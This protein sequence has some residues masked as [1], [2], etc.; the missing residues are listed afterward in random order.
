MISKKY[1]TWYCGTLIMLG[2]KVKTNKK[3]SK[4]KQKTLVMARLY[5]KTNILGTD[6]VEIRERLSLLL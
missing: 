4:D 6:F 3:Q 2:N 1:S 5:N